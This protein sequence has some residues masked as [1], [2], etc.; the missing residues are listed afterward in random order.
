MNAYEDFLQTDAAINPGNSGGPLVN[1]DGKVIGINSAIKSRTGGFQ[2][3]GLAISSNLGKHIVKKLLEEG[4]VKRGYLGVQIRDLTPEVAARLG[5]DGAGV[6]VSRVFDEGPAAL[7]K[8]REG[9]VVMSVAGKPVHD[10]QELQ[11]V[12]SALPLGQPAELRVVRDGPVRKGLAG[13]TASVPNGPIVV[14]ARHYRRGFF[15]AWVF[16]CPSEK[17]F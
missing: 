13:P 17:P 15:I 11:K 6:T 2:G 9:D 14:S 16:T 3:I 12:V 10:G 5:A 4:V 8:V 7:A 1:L